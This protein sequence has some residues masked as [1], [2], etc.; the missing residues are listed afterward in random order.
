M[1]K[2]T[3]INK[4]AADAMRKFAKEKL[5]SLGERISYTEIIYWLLNIANK[6]DK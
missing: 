1:T 4:D 2:Q 5:G 3:S 6:L